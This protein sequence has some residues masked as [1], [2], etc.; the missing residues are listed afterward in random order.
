MRVLAVWGDKPHADV[1]SD[2]IERR[3]GFPMSS[4]QIEICGNQ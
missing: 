2:G 3:H 1:G 4:F